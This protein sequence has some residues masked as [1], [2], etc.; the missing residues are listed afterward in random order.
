MKPA[1]K[2]HRNHLEKTVIWFLF[3]QHR[4]KEAEYEK[5][6]VVVSLLDLRETE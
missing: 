2:A 4:E 5:L 6:V 3:S 1:Q